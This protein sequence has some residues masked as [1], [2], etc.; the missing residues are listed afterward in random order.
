MGSITIRSK[1]IKYRQKTGKVYF[2]YS[3]LQDLPEWPESPLLEILQGELYVVPSPALI[4][5]RVSGRMEF[6]LRN[7]VREHDLG[8]IFDVPTDVVFS[9]EEVVVPDLLFIANENKKILSEKAIQGAPDLIV[10]VLSS[11]IKRD[12]VVKKE[13]YE[14]N[15]VKEY[16]IVDPTE[17]SVEIY[18]LEEEN[19]GA[20]AA[21]KPGREYH[22]NE[23][24][25][26]RALPGL[27]VKVN[28]LFNDLRI[29]SSLTLKTR[30]HRGD[31]RHDYSTS[32]K[33]NEKSVLCQGRKEKTRQSHP[34]STLARS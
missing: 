2:T 23:E 30:S 16:I 17:Q 22:L 9:D 15:R 21:Y 11:N 27:M 28:Y 12:R 10:E 31:L 18:L 20:T 3:N 4:H 7:F 1:E 6:I 33:K 5:Q 26:I 14:K 8:E 19:E 32:N 24:F 25:A 29:A 34:N 13:L